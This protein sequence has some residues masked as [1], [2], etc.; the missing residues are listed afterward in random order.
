MS[1]HAVMQDEIVQAI[2]LENF[3][4]MGNAFLPA[5]APL[6][7]L[8]SPCYSPW[9]ALIQDLPAL[10]KARTL[11]SQVDR[12]EVLG[13]EH[14]V[15]EEE[16][17]RAYVI[18]AF[19]SHAYIWG[20]ERPAEV[21]P[22]S[23][24]VPFL[25]AS[26]HLELPPVATYAALNLW[27]FTSS[28]PDF[29]DLDSLR[30]LNTFTGTQDESWFYCVSVAMEAQ[31]ASII[32]VMVQALET[33]RIRGFS[34]ITYALDELSRCICQ[35]GGLLDRMSEKCDPNV[36]FHHIRPYLTGSKNMSAAGLP[37]GVFY[38]E[39]DGK[40]SWRQL[41][42]GSNGQSSLIQFFDIVL[43]V[44]HT[45]AGNSRPEK[46]AKQDK[47]R[48]PE[49]SFHEEV[50]GYMP[51]P[52]RRFLE[53]VARM[54]SIRNLALQ[55][56][57]DTPEE[58]QLHDAYTNA[59]KTLAEFRNKH[60]QIVTRYIVIPST[61][62]RHRPTRE[63]NLATATFTA[64]SHQETQSTELTG[65]GGTALLPFLKQSRDE[66]YRAGCAN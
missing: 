51:G 22:P 16:W 1:P 7:R 37:R 63:I 52:H 59:T 10:L 25:K 65:T 44:E 60:L 31:A 8:R 62:Q 12:L 55:P 19:L 9:E 11:R 53:R 66:T 64:Q 27:N 20:G 58:Q 14:L 50:R 18:L 49:T 54:G 41:R 36:F 15:L 61:Q 47:G 38:D 5:K 48:Q 6:S 30:S 39:G 57:A 56:A 3:G 2:Q 24:S 40:G 42:G 23:I 21:L 45:S 17:R 35:I 33:V 4:V 13:T 26:E 43:G 34:A 32:P 29:T 28:S 46:D